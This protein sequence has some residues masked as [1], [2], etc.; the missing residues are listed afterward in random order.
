MKKG[1]GWA[2]LLITLGALIVFHQLGIHF[3]GFIRAIMSYLFPLALVGLGYYGIKR[4]RNIGWLVLIVGGFMLLHKLAW[5]L[6]LAIGVGI[7]Y[8]GFKVLGKSRKDKKF[9]SNLGWEEK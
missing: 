8:Y 3:G 1:T 7:V 6:M 5:L 9:K 2:V 4:G